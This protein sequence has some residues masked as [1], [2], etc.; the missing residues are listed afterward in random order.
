VT[1]A[2]TALEA[3]RDVAL[4]ALDLMP[5]IIANADRPRPGRLVLT[6]SMRLADLLRRGGGQVVWVRSERPQESS[7]RAAG[8]PRDQSP[9]V[10]LVKQTWGAFTGTGLH[11]LLQQRAITTLWLTG[12]T[13][14]QAVESTARAADGLG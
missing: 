9:P 4:V 3:R 5:R 13:T 10:Q 7:P 8:S 1:T 11:E 2:P 6:R 14:N 12:I